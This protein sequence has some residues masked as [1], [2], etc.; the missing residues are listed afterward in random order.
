MNAHVFLNNVLVDRFDLLVMSHN[1]FFHVTTGNLF[2][3][4]ILFTVCFMFDLCRFPQ[5]A[6]GFNRLTSIVSSV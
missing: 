6:L 3:V 2:A 1:R 4:V 5:I